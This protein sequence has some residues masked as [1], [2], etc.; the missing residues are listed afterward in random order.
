MLSKGY[1]RSAYRRLGDGWLMAHG[2][3][4]NR[5]VTML[6]TAFLAI[7]ARIKR[8]DWGARERVSR[9]CGLI[10]KMYAKEMERSNALANIRMIRCPRRFQRQL[11][12]W[13]V[14][15][16][17]HHISRV[18]FCE[19][20]PEIAKVKKEKKHQGFATWYQQ[21]LGEELIFRFVAEAKRKRKSVFKKKTEEEKKTF[22]ELPPFMRKKE[23]N[24]RQAKF[25]APRLTPGAIGHEWRHG[26]TIVLEWKGGHPKKKLPKSWCRVCFAKAQAAGTSAVK[27]DYARD[28]PFMPNSDG[29]ASE[30]MVPRPTKGCAVCKVNLCQECHA[31]G[32]DHMRRR[33]KGLV[34]MTG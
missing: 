6:S 27:G 17:G 31:T 30:K 25:D 1:S 18:I 11:Y 34:V 21:T 22:S 12:M 20:W 26:R 24:R 32:W 29:S 7:K 23:R 2:W 8:W 4:D 33:V 9:E 3:L 10:L 15:T 13:L 19:L 14:S 28:R 16:F 5:W